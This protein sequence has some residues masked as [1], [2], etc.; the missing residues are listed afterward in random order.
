MNMSV[1]DFSSL[2]LWLMIFSTD[3]TNEVSQYDLP[4]LVFV[5]GQ[6]TEAGKISHLVPV[7]VTEPEDQN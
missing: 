6:F 2:L 7:D 3:K 5:N 1:P 4:V